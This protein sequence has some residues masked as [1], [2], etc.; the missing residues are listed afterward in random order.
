MYLI[1]GDMVLLYEADGQSVTVR[2]FSIGGIERN[3]GSDID[4]SQG[5]WTP[6]G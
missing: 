2:L 1:S 5:W 4:Y 6:I 3:E